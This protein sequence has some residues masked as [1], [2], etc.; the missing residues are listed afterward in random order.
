MR[1]GYQ[2]H[3]NINN[4]N[5]EYST[6]N[7]NN[8]DNDSNENEEYSSH[9]EQEMDE[10]N[11]IN[12]KLNKSFT[13]EDSSSK[14]K[15]ASNQIKEKTYIQF[16]SAIFQDDKA[17]A[18]KIFK[19]ATQIISDHPS[20]EGYTPLQYAALYGSIE[21]FKYLINLKANTERKVEGL[22]LIH[23]S[24]SRAIFK[25]EKDKCIKMFNY[26]YEKLPEQRNLKDRLGRTF[27]HIIFEYDFYDALD[28]IK[29]NLDDLFISDNNNN[30]VIDY[31]Y[32]YNSNQCFFKVAKDSEFLSKLY[33][34]IRIKYESINKKKESFLENLFIHQ[35]IYSIAIIVINSKSLINELIEDLTNLKNFYD[36]DINKMNENINYALNIAKSLKEGKEY[37][38]QFIFPQKI[39]NYT[40]IVYN[41]NCI[42]H[43]KLPDEPLKHLLTRI[44]MLENSDRLAWLIHTENNGILLNDQV[45]HYKEDLKY[46]ELIQKKNFVH[47][48]CEKIY[49]YESNRKSCLN[50]IL[51]CHDLNYILK[52]RD[53]S[54]SKNQQNSSKKQDIKEKKCKGLNIQKIL[55]KID[56]SSNP[57]YKNI[58]TLNYQSHFKKVDIDTYI[59]E[60]SFENIFNTS[61][62]VLDAVDLVLQNKVSN[63]LVLIRPPGHNAGY[64]GPVE[65]S[66]TSASLGFCLVNNVA[67]GAAYA[68]NKYRE[69]IKKILIFDFDVHHG[70]GTEEIVQ[71]L[72]NK[73]FEKKF[74]Y[75]KVCELT[76]QNV[77]QINWADENDAKNVLFI[78]MHIYDSEKNNY[79]PYSGDITSNT[80]RKSQIYPGGILNIPFSLKKNLSEEYISA[81]KTK[82]IPRIYEFKPDIIFL[83]AGFDGHENEIINHNYMNLTEFDYAFITQK[84]QY[85]ANK[86]CNG[87]L[88]SVL[89]GG[90]NISTGIISSFAQSAL[91]HARFLSLSLNMFQ[92]FDIKLTGIKRN[93]DD[94]DEELNKCTKKIKIENNIEIKEEEKKIESSKIK[95]NDSDD[96]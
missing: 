82:V 69:Y 58:F 72:N 56:I 16:I 20:L 77:K 28:R 81:F 50:D 36:N 78:S 91:T 51:K 79:Y 4:N 34:E 43:I 25:K 31:V 75:D 64:Y 96:N 63:A 30:Y 12:N 70:N 90:Y 7:S 24:L 53:I 85:L 44:L 2:N 6:I 14:I 46:E 42:Q 80:K 86:F 26:I 39:R 1:L 47:S 23:L 10:I 18:E 40:A 59:N 13:E 17:Q 54:Y 19:S 88:I 89:E 35:N 49:F 11:D 67:I 38:Q 71:M 32:I 52:L 9:Q 15:K 76:T 87:R 95:N 83:S 94:D 45:C 93:N 84:M 68:K 65:I 3:L 73:V 57:L 92:D 61:G 66:S 21:C 37:S 55:N 22:N 62:C 60:Y 8:Q 27:L 33:K 5:Q 41:N 29:F 48:G 74:S